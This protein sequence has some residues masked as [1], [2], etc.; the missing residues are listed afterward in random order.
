MKEYVIFMSIL[1]TILIVYLVY[2][3]RQ[4]RRLKNFYDAPGR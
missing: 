3:S 2:A 4:R 1:A